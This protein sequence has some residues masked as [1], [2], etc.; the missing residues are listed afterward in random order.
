MANY[1]K[2][3]R[4][5]PRCGESL[6]YKNHGFKLLCRKCNLYFDDEENKDYKVEGLEE[7]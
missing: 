6:Y 5:C 4:K 7:V 2:I 3:S 1:I